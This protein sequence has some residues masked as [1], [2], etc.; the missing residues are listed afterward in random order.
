MDKLYFTDL[1]KTRAISWWE[2]M[3]SIVVKTELSDGIFYVGS[4]VGYI[5]SAHVIVCK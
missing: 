3:L 4:V 2:L 5:Y 1:E